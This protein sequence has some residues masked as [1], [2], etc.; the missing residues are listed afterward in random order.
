MRTPATLVELALLCARNAR[1]ASSRDVA[2]ALW[3]MA[4]EY[5]TQAKKAGSREVPEI[6]EPPPQLLLERG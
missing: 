4:V 6:G 1:C 2:A 5:Q 3:K